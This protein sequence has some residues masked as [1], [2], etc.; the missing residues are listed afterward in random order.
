M[1]VASAIYIIYQPITESTT[2]TDQLKLFLIGASA[3]LVRLVINMITM[4]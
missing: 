1:S 4:T 3:R 2:A